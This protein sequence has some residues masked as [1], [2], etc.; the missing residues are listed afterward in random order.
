[1]ALL[2]LIVS[3]FVA[4]IATSAVYNLFFH[5]LAKTAGPIICRI[6]VLPSFYHAIKG[7]RHVWI[8]QNFQRYGNTFRA[9]PNLVL[10]NTQR[11]FVDIYSARANT[12]RSGFYRAWKRNVHD[13]NTISCTEPAL[14]A[15]KR[16][17]L[18]LAFTE[19][20]LKIAGP[21]MAAH[22][23]RW[24]E[25]LAGDA[26]ET[27]SPPRN[28]A[29]WV[30]FLVFDILGDL[31]FGENFNA[32]EPGENKLK[33]IPH[34][35]MRHMRL[36]YIISKSSL[37]DLVLFLQPRGLNALQERIRHVD[38]KAY[39]SFV[40]SRVDKRIAAHKAGVES[41]RHDMFHFLLNAVD[42][43]TNLP[44]YTER[45][46]LLAETRLLV[47]AGTDTSAGTMCGLF[48]Y[49]AHNP[50]V[51]VKLTAEIRST[52]ASVK[53]I[54]LSP[55]L[56]RCQYLRACIDEALRISPP[57]PGELP[58]EVL[59]GGATI[60]GRFYPEGT[61]VGC[62]A[63]SMGRD[64]TVYGDAGMYRPER[65]IPS[66]GENIVEEEARV[67]ELKRKFHPFLM[68]P[69]DCAGRNV[70]MLELLLVCARTV[71]RMDIRL[72]PGCTTGE[73]KPELGWGQ[74][75]PNQYIVRDSFLCLKDGPVLQFK[76]RSE[77]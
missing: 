19:Q 70:A 77:L 5:P 13:L 18:N 16:K 28:M 71:W 66:L 11:A 60:Q 55:K 6:S 45:H 17:A 20:S 47:L 40:E 21:L 32:K 34:L 12:A 72:A 39:N 64:E 37:L 68:G 51:L 52:F 38:M 48:F 41:N 25:L 54:M 57:A 29:T 65:W 27:W 42:P 2:Y 1:M 33:Q 7:D 22:I 61:I 73:G 43:E 31:F 50:R 36:G 30:D 53:E 67:R 3:A 46:N 26:A 74:R 59:P 63:W 24:D 8:W 23:D 44:A 9:A 14:H 49:L 35:I 15:K 76:Q 69:G 75:S 62:A 58:R 56:S 10:F 4:Y